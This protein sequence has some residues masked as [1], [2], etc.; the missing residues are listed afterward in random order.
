MACA[1]AED[2]ARA[3]HLDTPAQDAAEQAEDKAGG[4]T[5]LPRE[6]WLADARTARMTSDEGRRALDVSL[7]VTVEPAIDQ[8]A[9]CAAWQD[10]LPAEIARHVHIMATPAGDATRIAL[11]AS[12]THFNSW[13][14]ALAMQ[15]L[16]A[17]LGGTPAHAKP[18]T[19][20]QA[21]RAA[22]L[23]QRDGAQRTRHI[24]FWSEM[25]KDLPLP[26]PFAQ[27]SRALAPVGFGLNRGPTARIAALF[28]NHAANG[29][30]TMLSAFARSLAEVTGRPDFLIACEIDG[31]ASET[32]HAM[33]GPLAATVPLVCRVDATEPPE[34][35]SA[36]LARDMHHARTHAAFDLAACEEA[37]GSAW[38]A[39]GIVP[40]QIGFSHVSGNDSPPALLATTR[41]R[42]RFGR[43]T[44]RRED[45]DNAI[46]NDLR[47]AVTPSEE[48][49]RAE[50]AYDSDVVSAA[51]AQALLDAFL[52]DLRGGEPE[53]A[54]PELSAQTPR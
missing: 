11:R 29:A 10:V 48:G 3:A 6:K 17:R 25:L 9:L 51:F 39:A 7:A 23:A 18:Q 38:R 12:R 24:A 40:R 52:R 5:L 43:L 26:V 20:W 50:I 16:L 44:V 21:R 14:A 15:D 53:T 1:L 30:S 41:A 46:E 32:E 45:D 27:R 8:A 28:S 2:S 54:K 37:F 47:L 49:Y 31:R 22:E 34:A 35:L 13:S 33:I 19:D 4:G 42:L 36:R